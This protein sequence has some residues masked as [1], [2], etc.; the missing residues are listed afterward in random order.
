MTGRKLAAIALA[1]SGALLVA[2]AA[3]IGVVALFAVAGR[4][5]GLSPGLTIGTGALCGMV[6]GFFAAVSCGLGAR[7]ILRAGAAPG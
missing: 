1:G 4:L 6:A 5:L 2:P 3:W 7:L